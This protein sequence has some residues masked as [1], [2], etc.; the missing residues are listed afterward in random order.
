MMVRGFEIS[1]F[2]VEKVNFSADSFAFLEKVQ[3]WASFGEERAKDSLV[4]SLK[5]AKT[6][7]EA[8]QAI[9]LYA[10]SI[11]KNYSQL[12]GHIK[13]KATKGKTDA[14]RQISISVH[15]GYIDAQKTPSNEIGQSK[16][17]VATGQVVEKNGEQYIPFW[18]AKAKLKE[19]SERVTYK[20][21]AYERIPTGRPI[22]LGKQALIDS[23][24]SKIPQNGANLL[25][26]HEAKAAHQKIVSAEQA[27]HRDAQIKAATIA[28]NLK[29]AESVMKEQE[30]LKKKFDA[31]E[32]V[33]E[34][35]TVS[36]HNYTKHK[37]DLTK[38]EWQH[39]NVTVKRSGT[40]AYVIHADGKFF[41]KELAKIKILNLHAEL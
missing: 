19:L 39:S 18:L 12:I 41:I 34:N 8:Q 1:M 14:G 3:N 29:H 32:V 30:R 31:L 9:Y 28:L 23:L 17:Y 24:I 11:E 7:D 33:A 6:S 36:G 13:V 38:V 27:V 21:Q 25:I 2:G 4:R 40:R 15:K 35:A 16:F 10:E 20:N 5:S 22:W 26:D 37:G